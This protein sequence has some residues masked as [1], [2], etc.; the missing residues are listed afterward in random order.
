MREKRKGRMYKK[1]RKA[2]E[3]MCMLKKVR[4]RV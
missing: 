3:R 1:E 2:K 4:L